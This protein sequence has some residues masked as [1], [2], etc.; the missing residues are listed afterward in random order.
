MNPSKYTTPK[1]MNFEWPKREMFI[2]FQ[3]FITYFNVVRLLVEKSFTEG[4]NVGKILFHTNADI[5]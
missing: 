5:G 4:K 2:L 3:L 1:K